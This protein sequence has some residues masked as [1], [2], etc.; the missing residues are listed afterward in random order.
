MLV[1]MRKPFRTLMIS[2]G[3]LIALGSLPAC[4]GGSPSGP[5]T[6]AE[7]STTATS[8]AAAPA[9]D[10]PQTAR[11]IADMPMPDGAR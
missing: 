3:A 11:Y 8:A 10:F 5:A 7:S 4:S 9:E 2:T 1:S 6:E